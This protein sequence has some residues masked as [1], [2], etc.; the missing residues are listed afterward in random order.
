MGDVKIRNEIKTNTLVTTKPTFS[1]SL[2]IPKSIL[3]LGIY[4]ELRLTGTRFSKAKES[5][6]THFHTPSGKAVCHAQVIL[7]K[8]LNNYDKLKIIDL[9]EKRDLSNFDFHKL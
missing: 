2:I 5:N 6:G 3:F 7:E 1:N 9:L 4:S 8:A